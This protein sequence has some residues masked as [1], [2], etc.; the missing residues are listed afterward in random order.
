MKKN[1]CRQALIGLTGLVLVATS[2]AS[3]GADSRLNDVISAA[4]ESDITRQIEV[5]QQ[6][7]GW[8][9][10]QPEISTTLPSGSHRLACSQPL[11]VE[12]R[13]KRRFPAGN[14][15]YRVT[16][17][18]VSGWSI[19]AQ[20]HF[21]AQV[22]VAYAKHTIAKDSLISVE[23][24]E[25]RTMP[26]SRLSRDFVALPSRLIN[27]RAQR[28]IRQGRMISPERVSA[29]YII[30]RGE[31]VVMMASGDGFSTS[32]AGVALESGYDNQQIRVRNVRSGNIIN[33]IIIEPGK[34]QTLF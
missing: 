28:Q 3:E 4:I 26:L 2:V 33:A 34:V 17:S 18:E 27:Q 29:P 9:L 12:R 32:T 21:D 19:Q 5:S 24:I 8:Q 25:M 10:E 16:C 11:E 22:Q 31:Q 15:R 14:L 20:A 1:I 6:N 23:D 13:D 30:Q 7:N